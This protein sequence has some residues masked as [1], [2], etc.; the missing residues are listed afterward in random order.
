MSLNCRS[1]VS[2]PRGRYSRPIM[3]NMRIDA[4]QHFWIFNPLR[5]G[6]IT[7]EM[8]KIRRDFLPG[9]LFSLLKENGFD[10]CVTVQADPSE[11]ETEFLLGLAANNL[12]V[13]G[14]VG[15][16]DLCAP[17]VRERL[18]Y[19]S[20][21]KLLKGVRHIVQAEADDFLLREDFCR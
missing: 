9:D 8:K 13:K 14:V 11:E 3:P 16:I 7:E 6:W 5:D 20:G 4:H 2:E 21:F 19:F 10:G 18:E 1:K 17:N 15:W 12:F